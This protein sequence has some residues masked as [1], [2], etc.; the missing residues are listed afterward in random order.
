[1]PQPSLPDDD[2]VSVI[3]EAE[4]I[5]GMGGRRRLKRHSMAS[6][7]RSSLASQWM[8]DERRNLIAY[9]YLCHIGEAKDWIEQCI[10][11]QTPEIPELANNAL[12]DGVILAKLARKFEPDCVPRIFEHPKLQFRHSDNI[13][14]V[15]RF[16]DK[17]GLPENFHFELTDLYERKNI[18][19]V[20]YCIHALSHLMAY[21]HRA[22]AMKDLVGQLEFT[23]QVL[24]ETGRALANANA[25][26]PAFKSVGTALAMELKEF[27]L[28]NV[29]NE[30]SDDEDDVPLADVDLPRSV[31]L[32]LAFADDKSLKRLE[33]LQAV[34]R[35]WSCRKG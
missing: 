26:M 22:P 23:E 7:R 17:V 28:E 6:S 5:A 27:T 8:D 4:E 31:Q 30:A 11:E 35:G 2:V 9:E 29:A 3:S 34:V 19:K 16:I 21:R 20:I 14:Y 32:D 13:N 12:R 10:N 15:F 1:M 25:V 33:K 24:D 18:P